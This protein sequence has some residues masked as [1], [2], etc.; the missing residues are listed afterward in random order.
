MNYRDSP[1]PNHLVVA[2]SGRVFAMERE[3]GNRVWA[4]PIAEDV[5]RVQ[6]VHD[7]VIAFAHG[8]GVSC[9]DIRDGAE[10]WRTHLPGMPSADSLLCD[11]GH[12]FAG[13][14]G[15][16]FCLR[17]TD[18]HLLWHDPF[19][20]KGAGAIAIAIHGASSQADT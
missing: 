20:G 19:K 4:K 8:P 5:V 3:S 12:V 15:E 17:I 10:I 6:V 16:V 14:S 18:G 7:R 2:F 1:V 9:L 11:E 13:G